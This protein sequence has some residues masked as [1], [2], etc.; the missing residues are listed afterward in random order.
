[1]AA[2]YIVLIEKQIPGK[3][4]QATL[5]NGLATALG[6]GYTYQ[7]IM[8]DIMNAFHNHSSLSFYKYDK[9]TQ[10]NLIKSGIVYY[11]KELKLM[12]ALPV[13]T[14]DV[15]SGTITSSKVDYYLEPV[16]SYTMEDLLKYFYSKG[17]TDEK[18]YNPRRMA[19]I[20]KHMIEKYSLDKVLFMIEAAARMYQSDKKIFSLN[21]F[22]G[23][24][25]TA[26]GYLEQIINN[27]KY[28][29]GDKYVLRKRVLF[30]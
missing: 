1:M 4:K 14:H 19:G 20:L 16:A 11:H 30:G 3:S 25:Q 7:D 29:G 27:C 23:Y 15:D 6:N 2:A 22:E 18:E 10:K 5:L 24:S 9:L 12:S 8:K 21:D 28:S 17:M 26:K 13:V